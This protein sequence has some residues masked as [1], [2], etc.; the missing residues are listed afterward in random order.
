[1]WMVN[2][3]QGWLLYLV[4]SEDASHHECSLKSSLKFPLPKGCQQP[5]VGSLCATVATRLSGLP[6]LAWAT[7]KGQLDGL[8]HKEE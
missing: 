4:P 3:S 7:N 2:K 6:G 8:A 5:S 1:M